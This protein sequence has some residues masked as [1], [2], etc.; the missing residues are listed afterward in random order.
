MSIYRPITRKYLRYLIEGLNADDTGSGIFAQ[1]AERLVH[2]RKCANI[3]PATEPSA[4]GDY[5]QDARTQQVLLDA[6]GRFRFYISPPVVNERWIFAFSIDKNWQAKLKRDAKKIVENQLS[7][8]RIIYVTN[9]FISPEHVKI[10]MERQIQTLYNI[11]CEILDGQW[12][13]DNLYEHDYT[14][15]VDLLECPPEEDPELMAIW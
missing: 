11:P 9:R 6:D 1:L 3:V 10:D 12:F 7:P 8:D 4:G 14:L 2:R 15:A 13:L 5:G